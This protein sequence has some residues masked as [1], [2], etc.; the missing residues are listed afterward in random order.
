MSKD[1]KNRIDCGNEV[2]DCKIFFSE[3][4]K[5]EELRKKELELIKSITIGMRPD[6]VRQEIHLTECIAEIKARDPSNTGERWK[7][8]KARRKV[9]NQLYQLTQ[10]IRKELNDGLNSYISWGD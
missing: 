4:V 8:Y 6:L 1:N 10:R 3:Y 7:L 2:E 5:W 9:R